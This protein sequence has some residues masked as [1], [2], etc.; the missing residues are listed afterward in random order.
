MAITIQVDETQYAPG[1][2]I[3]LTEKEVLDAYNPDWPT[4]TP[5]GTVENFAHDDRKPTMFYVYPPANNSAYVEVAYVDNPAD[6]ADASSA[7]ALPDNYANAL[8]NYMLMRAA[9]KARQTEAA[10]WF[11]AQFNDALG[12]KAATDATGS[13]NVRNMDGAGYGRAR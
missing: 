10:N 6:C 4:D 12:G 2:A 7:I 1:R 11:Q 5:S 8:L 13:P 9:T 3:S